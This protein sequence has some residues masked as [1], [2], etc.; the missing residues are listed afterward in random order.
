MKVELTRLRIVPTMSGMRGFE[1]T[2]DIEIGIVIDGQALGACR[3]GIHLSFVQEVLRS[4]KR[5]L[6]NEYTKSIVT[7]IG[8][9]I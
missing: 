2:V 8:E 4:M 9:L 6:A 1:D 3:G 5:D 7:K